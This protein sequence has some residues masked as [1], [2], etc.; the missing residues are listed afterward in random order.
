MKRTLPLLAAAAAGALFTLAWSA[1]D[2]QAGPTEGSQNCAAVPVQLVMN[3]TNLA[4]GKRDGT[5]LPAGW[6]AV[7]GAGDS[8]SGPLVVACKTN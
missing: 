5:A 2:A 7:G 6:V 4:N 8:S 3:P 1:R